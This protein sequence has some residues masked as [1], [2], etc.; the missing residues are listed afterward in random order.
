MIIYNLW[1]RIDSLNLNEMFVS[2]FLNIE[3]AERK[4]NILSFLV[5]LCKKDLEIGNHY[6]TP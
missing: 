6:K 5:E 1:I 2:E 3:N 4:Q